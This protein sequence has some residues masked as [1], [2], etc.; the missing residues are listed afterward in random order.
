MGAQE[1]VIPLD[2][3]GDRD[4]P[5][6]GGKAS[7]L[8][9]LRKAGFRV[10]PGFCVTTQSYDRFLEEAGLTSV[11]QMELGRK[12]LDLMRWEEI[13]DAALRIRNRFTAAEMPA[14]VAAAIVEAADLL[15]SGVR[16]AVRSS[17]P[18]GI[19]LRKVG[20]HLGWHRCSW[21]CQV[22]GRE[23]YRLMF[24]WVRPSVLGLA[25]S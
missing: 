5:R 20:I 11:I 9:R 4:E 8:A 17:A 16:L 10:A 25:I 6:I 13:W 23:C 18:N 2:G 21:V 1:W 7:T 12:P 22:P 15:G 24:M 3:A 14:D 19:Q